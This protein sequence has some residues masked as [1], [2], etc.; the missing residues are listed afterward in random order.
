MVDPNQIQV[1]VFERRDDE[2]G[3]NIRN[4]NYDSDG[5]L[6]N[7]PYGFFLPD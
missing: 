3:S 7:W 5:G 2:V 1:L 4:A 6:V